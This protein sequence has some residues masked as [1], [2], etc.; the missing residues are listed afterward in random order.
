MDSVIEA[1]PIDTQVNPLNYKNN[2]SD[3]PLTVSVLRTSQLVSSPLLSPEPA[4]LLLHRQN[5]NVPQALVRILESSQ[6][7][8]ILVCLTP[9]QHHPRSSELLIISYYNPQAPYSWTP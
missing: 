9:S 2:P 6:L 1:N 3:I 5:P 4:V 8:S 7:Q